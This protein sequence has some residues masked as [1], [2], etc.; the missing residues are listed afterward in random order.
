MLAFAFFVLS[1][2]LTILGEAHLALWSVALFFVLAAYAVMRWTGLGHSLFEASTSRAQHRAPAQTARLAKSFAM[3]L[4]IKENPYET[5][6]ISLLFLATLLGLC[7]KWANAAIMLVL[8]A[9]VLVHQNKKW[10]ALG[11]WVIH[12][13]LPNALHHWK[14]LWV[15]I[16]LVG[17]TISMMNGYPQD[18]SSVWGLSMVLSIITIFGLWKGIGRV[19]SKA[20]TGGFGYGFAGISLSLVLL[21]VATLLYNIVGNDT[22]M[23][24]TGILFAASM[25]SFWFGM[26][27]IISDDVNKG[28]KK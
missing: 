5:A 26:W 27:K 21:G 15:G 23:Q 3:P 11:N 8:A 10:G 16:S 25:V 1:V 2:T 6:F 7:G 22:A 13:V 12:S 20:L 18:V 14:G 4:F 17:L 19:L 9:A 24:K 28:K